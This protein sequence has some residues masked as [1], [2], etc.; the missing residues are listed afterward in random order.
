MFLRGCPVSIFFFFAN[1]LLHIEQ[2]QQAGYY[3]NN[4]L[5]ERF[6]RT[7]NPKRQTKPNLPPSPHFHPLPATA[8][9]PWRLPPPAPRQLRP[10]P[11]HVLN[12]KIPIIW[13]LSPSTR[14]RILRSPP[15]KPLQQRAPP[16][17]SHQAPSTPR[18]PRPASP[19]P[20]H[21]LKYTTPSG[22]APNASPRPPTSPSPSRTRGDVEVGLGLGTPRMSPSPAGIT[23][24]AYPSTSPTRRAWTWIRGGVPHR[25]RRPR[26]PR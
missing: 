11:L 23:P 18:P 3:K 14:R 5:S 9:P 24:W 22:A 21:D 15:V 26:S 17:A 10:P 25:P 20:T 13:P 12:T 1:F 6:V 19:A 7:P 8:Q 4:R 16:S 2:E